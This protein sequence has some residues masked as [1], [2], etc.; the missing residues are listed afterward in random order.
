[1]P[2]DRQLIAAEAFW[3]DE[4][5]LEQQVEA[6]ALLARRMKARPKFIASLPVARRAKYLVGYPGMP[7]LLAARLLVSYHLAHQRPM[8]RTFLDALGI[9]HDDGVIAKDP[10]GPIAPDTI[11][12][13]V[14]ALDAAFPK[15]DVTLYLQTLLTQDPQT[16]GALESIVQGR[17]KELPNDE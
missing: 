4:D 14:A 10:E 7:D 17:S 9:A 11:E 13:A 8:L 16:W 3:Q 1:M 12:L 15:N 5:G 6:M 2:E